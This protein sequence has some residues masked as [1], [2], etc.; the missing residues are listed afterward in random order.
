[1]WIRFVFV[2]CLTDAPAIVAGI[3]TFVASLPTV[4]RVEVTARD[5]VPLRRHGP[6]DAG[7]RGLA[8]RHF[9][10]RGLLVGCSVT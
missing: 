9:R 10:D 1:M 8:Q 7:T 2:P 6:A 3:A 5:S 4:E